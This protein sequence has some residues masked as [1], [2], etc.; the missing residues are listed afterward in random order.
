MFKST[1]LY[2]AE[3]IF[4]F[5]RRSKKPFV[6]A[7]LRSSPRDSVKGFRKLFVSRE[8]QIKGLP[9]LIKFNW[10]YLFH[11]FYSGRFDRH[12]CR[13]GRAVSQHNCCGVGAGSKLGICEG[14]KLVGLGAR[15]CFTVT[16]QYLAVICFW[17]YCLTKFMCPSFLK[18]IGGFRY[19]F[20]RY[21]WKAKT[22]P[23][24]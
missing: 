4:W 23:K 8:A 15:I 21:F 10:I 14:G 11:N 18:L 5:K 17:R 24:K 2:V 13:S 6:V 20:L 16:E 1:V 3:P 19:G 22:D 7:R 9:F 12:T